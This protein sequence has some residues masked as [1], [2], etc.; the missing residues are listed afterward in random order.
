MIYG[1]WT[2]YQFTVAVVVV[3]ALFDLPAPTGLV[4]FSELQPT[5]VCIHLL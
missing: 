4:T 5:I 1:L 3:I 2:C